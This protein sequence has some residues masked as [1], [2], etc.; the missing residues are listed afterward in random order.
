VEKAVEMTC[1]FSK[2]WLAGGDISGEMA[3]EISA[4]LEG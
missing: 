4:F 1:A 2:V 3:R